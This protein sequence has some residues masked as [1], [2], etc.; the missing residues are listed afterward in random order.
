MI[1]FQIFNPMDT[2]YLIQSD[3]KIKIIEIEIILNK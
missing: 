3:F 2:H 1:N